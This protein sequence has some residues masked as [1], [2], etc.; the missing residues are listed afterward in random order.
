M[1]YRDWARDR[2]RLYLNTALQRAVFGPAEPTKAELRDML[3]DAVRNTAK[4]ERR[5]RRKGRAQ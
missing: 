5:P 1:E 4:L 3:R 2:H